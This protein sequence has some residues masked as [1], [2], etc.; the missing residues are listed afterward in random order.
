[1]TLHNQYYV[2]KNRTIKMREMDIEGRGNLI[3]MRGV[4]VLATKKTLTHLGNYTLKLTICSDDISSL[5]STN[6]AFSKH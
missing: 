3:T 5:P 4:S 6:H 1:M 2:L